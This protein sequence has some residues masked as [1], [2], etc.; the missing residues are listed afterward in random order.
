MKINALNRTKAYKAGISLI[1]LSIII[2]FGISLTLKLIS[3]L[4]LQAQQNLSF[5]NIEITFENIYSKQLEDQ[6]RS[7]IYNYTQQKNLL[8]FNQIKFYKELKKE[9]NIIKNFECKIKSLEL[10]LKIKGITPFCT[11]NK[12]LIFG[13]K[14]K[15]FAPEFFQDFDIKNL[16]NININDN[17]LSNKLTQ[18]LFNF[19]NNIPEKQ[20]HNFEINYLNSTKI[21]LIPKNPNL[22][23]NLITHEKNLFDKK[24][25]R[26]AKKIYQKLIEDEKLIKKLNSK[27]SAKLI[28][29]LRFKNRII[30]KFEN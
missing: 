17:L 1:I 10:Y 6:I 14:K 28:L 27:K 30:T 29:D 24:K 12:Q 22:K 23:F 21:T 5:K 20:W 18:N 9:F 16:P 4:Q 25:L 8:T 15:L 19:I 13:N 11:V 2:S 7:F 26:Q 3:T